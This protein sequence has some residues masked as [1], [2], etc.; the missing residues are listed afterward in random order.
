MLEPAIG[1]CAKLDRSRRKS[2]N[3]RGSSL[4]PSGAR[5]SLRRQSLASISCS[6]I[7]EDTSSWKRAL[8]LSC[9]GSHQATGLCAY[10]CCARWQE[11]A[12]YDAPHSFC[13]SP[14]R[15][16]HAPPVGETGPWRA[17]G[18]RAR[19]SRPAGV[20]PRRLATAD[21]SPCPRSSGRR[22]PSMASLAGRAAI[23]TDSSRPTHAPFMRACDATRV[24][25]AGPLS[26]CTGVG[27]TDSPAAS[28]VG[29]QR[30]ANA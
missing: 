22:P 8:T 11:N 25:R 4:T 28:R 19:G 1:C 21:R 15:Y 29:A 14:Q 3:H 9:P 24:T 16:G 10:L 27:R 26:Q 17:A 13:R 5:A 7:V 2:G 18:D 20:L 30:V 12:L 23:F 6:S